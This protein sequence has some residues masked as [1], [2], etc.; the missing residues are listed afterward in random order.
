MSGKG[1][2]NKNKAVLRSPA[3][4]FADNKSIAGFDNVCH[5]PRCFVRS[6]T[7]LCIQK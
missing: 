7:P 2:K 1:K 4:F 5:L 3:E 6:L